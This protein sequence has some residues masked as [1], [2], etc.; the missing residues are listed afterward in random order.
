MREI[1]FRGK[2]QNGKWAEGNFTV[3]KT[4]TFV[5][6]PDE[7]LC[8]Y[9]GAVQPDTVGQYTGMTDKAGTK[10]FEHDCIKYLHGDAIGVIQYGKYRNAFDGYDLLYHVGFF[11]DWV[12]GAGKDLLRHDLGFWLKKV[13]VIGNIH[14]NPELM[15][16]GSA[17]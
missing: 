3:T 5:I 17:E 15:I 4:G 6:T 9:Y 11:V 14:D 16:G 12:S 8:G 2:L 13:E 1:L 7:T 10:V